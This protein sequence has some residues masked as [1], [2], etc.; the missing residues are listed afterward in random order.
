[1]GIGE[2]KAGAEAVQAP[3]R[4]HGK[5][6]QAAVPDGPPS[7]L[8]RLLRFALN[9]I[10]GLAAL[11]GLVVFLAWMGGAFHHKVAPGEGPV[12]RP[13]A[14][15][16]PRVT[17]AREAVEETTSVVATVQPRYKA[18]VAAQIVATIRDVKVDPGQRVAAG[19]LLVELDDR[20]LLAR[21][22]EAEAAITAARSDAEVRR[23]EY[24]RAAATKGSVSKEELDQKEGAYA[25]ARAQ[26][27]RL[28]EQARGIEVMLSYTRIKAAGPGTVVGRYK[29]PGDL[30]SPGQP[31][32]TIQDDSVLEL[33]ASVP[34]SLAG[35]VRVG[36]SLAFRID[37]AGA[38]G[39][40]TVR[41]V[42]PLAQQAT[43]S[44]LIKVT[45]PK[46]LA[47]PPSQP[48]GPSPLAGMFARVTVPVGTARRLLV[49]AQAISQ[50]GQ[51]ELV[52][53]VAADG[54][55]ERRMVRTGRTEDGK[56]E[57]LSGLAE[58]EVVA[59]PAK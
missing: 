21:Q 56:V 42:V 23:K 13:A 57:V 12:E 19:D 36:Q 48:V 59:L 15:D 6:D 58:G 30:A 47:R 24:E 29:D 53:V 44:L 3:D 9:L 28:E 1:M 37:A 4:P 43:R 46:D 16:R 55:L 17:V 20:E 40:G 10:A 35:R 50:V 32:L 49:P 5:R 25:S 26:V 54:T 11:A 33:H 52:E 45:L 14:G 39:V 38:S 34:E 41:E 2:N 7:R 18:D 22:R 51:L 27:K 8:A 31:I